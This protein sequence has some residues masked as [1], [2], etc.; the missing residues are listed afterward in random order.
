[1]VRSP[2]LSL[3]EGSTPGDIVWDENQTIQEGKKEY[4]W[5]FTPK[6]KI[7][8]STA[9]GKVTLQGTAAPLYTIN[10]S[11]SGRGK[12]SPDGTVTVEKGKDILFTFTPDPG[13]K[14]GTVTLDNMDV[15]DK[16]KDNSYKIENAPAGG[17]PGGI[18]CLYL[19]SNWTV[20]I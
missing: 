11:T 19:L 10:V 17:F 5:T 16:V 15:T 18:N 14:L 9:A 1:M 8:Y 12:V 3:G 4:S 20:M 7:N 13:Y 6:D 2:D